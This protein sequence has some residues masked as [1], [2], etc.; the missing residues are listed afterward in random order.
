MVKRGTHSV[1]FVAVVSSWCQPL[2]DAVRSCGS[3]TFKKPS[4]VESSAS[5]GTTRYCITKEKSEAIRI[6]RVQ[7]VRRTD[8]GFRDEV[9]HREYRAVMR[10]YKGVI[11]CS[12]I[13]VS[14]LDNMGKCSEAVRLN[15]E[16]K[17]CW[18]SIV[19]AI[20]G[21][22]CGRDRVSEGD[23]R[24]CVRSASL[25]KQNRPG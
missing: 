4:V 11:P 17:C 16:L 22:L 14:N 10:V 3:M 24:V 23:R 15:N 12:R 19:G 8:R 2:G 9:C 1:V 18:V 5:N 7:L 21:L 20:E 13:L 6:G 25:I